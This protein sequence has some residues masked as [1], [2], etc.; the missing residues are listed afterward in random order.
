MFIRIGNEDEVRRQII[1][2]IEHIAGPGS[3]QSVT[4]HRI[5]RRITAAL[6]VTQPAQQS[7]QESHQIS[8]AIQG[9]VLAK[10]CQI[11]SVLV[12]IEPAQHMT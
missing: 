6:T 3:C 10:Y 1:D 8:E 4:F 11:D 2:H 7:I 12:H 9:D 5:G